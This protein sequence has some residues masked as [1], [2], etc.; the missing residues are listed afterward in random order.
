M[1]PKMHIEG[2]IGFRNVNFE[3]NNSWLTNFTPK[4]AGNVKQLIKSGNFGKD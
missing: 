3:K 2:D 1:C 4:P